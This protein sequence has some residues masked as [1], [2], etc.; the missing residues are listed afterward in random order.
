MAC[1]PHAAAAGRKRGCRISCIMLSETVA[2]LHV[3]GESE[4]Y[5]GNSWIDDSIVFGNVALLPFSQTLLT[6]LCRSQGHHIFGGGFLGLDNIGIFDRSKPLPDGSHLQ[7]ACPQEYYQLCTHCS[8]LKCFL[9]GQ[10]KQ[11]DGSAWMAFYALIM[12]KIA[13]ELASQA[14]HGDE[15]CSS[16]LLFANVVFISASAQHVVLS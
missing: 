10:F 6:G 9:T 5:R 3:V 11:A 7:Q 1:V 2:E 15:V 8:I 16:A 13:I 14:L 12:L 4:G